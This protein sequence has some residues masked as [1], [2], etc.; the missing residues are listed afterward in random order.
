MGCEPWIASSPFDPGSHSS[1]HALLPACLFGDFDWQTL[2]SRRAKRRAAC[3]RACPSSLTCQPRP[4]EAPNSREKFSHREMD[5]CTE[6]SV[7][8][9]LCGIWI[10]HTPTYNFVTLPLT[11]CRQG[12]RNA[13]SLIM[14]FFDAHGAA[15]ACR[16]VGPACGSSGRP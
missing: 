12:G 3:G 10:L 4:T 2:R 13:A 8:R 1:I 5:K 11:G 14:F 7:C 16:S 15:L 9:C 6:H